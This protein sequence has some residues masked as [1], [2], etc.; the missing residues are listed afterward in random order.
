MMKQL[1][2]S[3]YL[4]FTFFCTE[5][6]SNDDKTYVSFD[7][8]EMNVERVNDNL[9]RWIKFHPDSEFPCLRLEILEAGSN[10]LIKRKNICNVYDEA[11]KVTHDFKKLSFLDIYN[12]SV[13]S[14]TLTFELELSLLSQNVVNM[15]CSI[16]IENKDFSPLVCNRS[17]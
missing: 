2:I 8:I 12:L 11:L 15:N 7:V 10:A 3:I 17:E 6:I 1:M 13:E 9:F 5:A 16:K 14:Q 4:I